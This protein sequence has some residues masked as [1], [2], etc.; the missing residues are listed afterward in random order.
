MI[1]SLA[2]VL[3]RTDDG[4]A[5]PPPARPVVRLDDQGG[6]VVPGEP[7]P[8]GE[9]RGAATAGAG[10]AVRGR[11]RRL[12]ATVARLAERDRLLQGARARFWPDLSEREAAREIAAAIRRYASTAWWRE[13]V[14]D[15]VPARHA[16]RPAELWWR[17]LKVHDHP[18]SP[19]T[20]RRAIRRFS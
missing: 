4:A 5:V 12:P 2:P 14:L 13:R 15:T 11:G 8:T 9:P 10:E 1:R 17:L 20:V 16:G 7:E 3:A 6:A 19:E 18:P